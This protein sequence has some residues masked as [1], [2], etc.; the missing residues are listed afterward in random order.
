M[1]NLPPPSFGP[2]GGPGGSGG[3]GGQGGSPPPP[4]G[5]WGGF[6]P[7]SPGGPGNQPLPYIASPPPSTGK[8][9]VGIIAAVLAVL[10]IGGAAAFVL[11]RDSDDDKATVDTEVT[12]EE[13]DVTETSE[14]TETTEVT[15]T[16]VITETTET[17]PETTAPVT[18]AAPTTTAAAAETTV[19]AVTTTVPVIPAGAI[20]LGHEVYIPV[21]PGWTLSSEPD[22]VVTLTDGTISVAVQALT[23]IPGENPADLVQEYIDT[24]DTDF[25]TVS[26]G[27]TA[28][29]RRLDGEPAVDVYR[30]FYLT[31]DVASDF[32][33]AG[34]VNV[35]IRGDGL[36]LIYDAYGPSDASGVFPTDAGAI[37]LQSL[38]QAPAVDV[39]V[40]L[41]P[42]A[43]FRVTSVHPFVQVDGLVGFTAAP[44]FNV[45]A[46][47][48]GRGF[49]TNGPEDFQVDKVG[50]QPDTNAVAVAAQAVISQNYTGV[51]NSE[52]VLD[53]PDPFGVVHGS[54]A[55]TGT[56]VEGNPSAGAVDF[57]Y[58]PATQN[59]YIVFRTWFT[60]A[61]N[62]EPFPA[63][64]QFMLRSVFNSFTTIP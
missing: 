24:F 32:G 38:Q 16:T 12:V 43:P 64:S 27:P 57:Y 47:G 53:D 58:D 50:A 4:G 6:Q 8:K 62:S 30:T 60:G 17:V 45:I 15:E 46:S 21:P 48:N 11:T 7:G 19:P 63:H 37:L 31:Y 1:S 42:L 3:F 56:Y 55:W 54:Y 29:I 13:T 10:A 2:P 34:D 18:T 35:Y 28:N 20:D 25:E 44:G 14:A 41:T 39:T 36:S 33:L 22:A 51:T 40:P 52:I 49:V 26:Y 5:Q 59:G 61:D 23:R 9:K